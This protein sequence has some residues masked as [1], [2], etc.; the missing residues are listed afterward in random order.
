MAIK[1]HYNLKVQTPNFY[2]TFITVQWRKDKT[3]QWFCVALSSKWLCPL[4]DGLDNREECFIC[5][6]YKQAV[7]WSRARC[8]SGHLGNTISHTINNMCKYWDF[9]TAEKAHVKQYSSRVRWEWQLTLGT[10]SHQMFQPS[11]L[12]FDTKFETIFCSV[13]SVQ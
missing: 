3:M 13:W 11:H 4:S 6:R 7:K 10:I 5:L 2:M 9:G 8:N 12:Q 1:K